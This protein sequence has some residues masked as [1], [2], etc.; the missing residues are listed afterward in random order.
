MDYPQLERAISV[1]AKLR[2]PEEG[3][4]WDLKQTHTSLLKYLIEESYEY[5]YA[6]EM[7][8]TKKMEEELGDILLQ[9]LLH[10]QLASDDKHFTIEDVAKTLA[11]KMIRRH[12]HVFEKGATNKIDEKEIKDT[13][14]KI[15][16][17]EQQNQY[18]IRMEDAY[19]PALHA[20]DKIGA[21]SQ[22]V[23]FDWDK[24][25]D[26]I[27]KVDE[28]LVEVKEEI[29]K[30]PHSEKA[31]EEIGDLL[32]SVAQLSRHMGFSPEEALKAAN[33]KFIKRINKVE[34]L[35]KQDGYEMENLPTSTLEEYWV[36]IKK[37][38]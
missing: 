36:K 15:K 33:K 37:C 8:D 28:E 9:V 12:P 18:H 25:E 34:D 11:D 17:Q 3:C 16:A 19:S 27:A 35:V 38:D 26:V 31:F 14:K 1:I 2:D 30:D 32:F 6:V 24:I 29:Q 7:E 4:P 13:W 5:V 20:S 21:K 23:N 10:S 22:A